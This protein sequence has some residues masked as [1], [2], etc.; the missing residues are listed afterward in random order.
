VFS[1]PGKLTDYGQIESFNGG[2]W[3]ECL[4]AHWFSN[5]TDAKNMIS[6]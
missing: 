4:K 1:T 2:F 3:D 6:A 5:L